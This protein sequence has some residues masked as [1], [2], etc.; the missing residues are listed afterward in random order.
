MPQIKQV[1]EQ[2]SKLNE[3]LCELNKMVLQER[4]DIVGLN[5]SGLDAHRSEMEDIFI[6][7]RTLSEQA[8]ILIRTACDLSGISGEKGLMALITVV[9]KPD[10]ESFARLQKSIQTVSA[11]VENALAVNRALLEDSL[12][13]TNQSMAIFTGMLKNSSTYGQAGRFVESMDRS[14]II[15]RE[16]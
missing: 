9:P 4:E 2:L 1:Y 7:V 15:N 14:R 6:R 8:G 10:R 11:E 13:F 3:T 5:L 16:I 12:A